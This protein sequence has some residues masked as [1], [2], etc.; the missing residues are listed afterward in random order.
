[1]RVLGGTLM[2][3]GLIPI[4]DGCHEPGLRAHSSAL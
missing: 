3:E 1:M 4:E 2:K